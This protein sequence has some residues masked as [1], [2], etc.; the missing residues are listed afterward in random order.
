MP[1]KLGSAHL[2]EE[3]A[4][5]VLTINPKLPGKTC[6]FQTG[7]ERESGQQ[8][9]TDQISSNN[10]TRVH[11]KNTF[12]SELAQGDYY[13]FL[14]LVCKMLEAQYAAQQ[15]DVTYRKLTGI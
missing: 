12:N 13:S 9:F 4:T 14:V 1:K 8:V 11:F 6:N 5:L 15:V 7:R 10:E 2:S 3:G